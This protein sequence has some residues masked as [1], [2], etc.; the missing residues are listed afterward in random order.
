MEYHGLG[1]ATNGKVYEP[2]DDSFMAADLLESYLLA[3]KHTN[4]SILDIGT[5][6][7]ILGLTAAKSEKATSITFADISSDAIAL[8]KKNAKSNA[9]T[10]KAKCDFALGNL[11]SNIGERKFD[12][13]TFNAP[14]LRS[15]DEGA[16]LSNAWDGGIE[17]VELSM[18]FIDGAKE[19]L[20][21]GG[22]IL[23]VYSSLSNVP[24]LMACI[25]D[26][27]FV[28]VK[29]VKKHQFFEDICAAIFVQQKHK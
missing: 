13:I 11:F 28:V 23:L 17:G 7:G 9:K 12:I 1:I 6:T 15:N 16:S 29:E 22:C 4:L 2:S 18:R 14:Y 5:G 24:V 27:G 20:K 10:I 19:H 21:I 26:E 25:A 8:A 3:C